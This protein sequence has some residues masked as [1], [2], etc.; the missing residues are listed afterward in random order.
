[1]SKFLTTAVT[2]CETNVFKEK[3]LYKTLS[4]YNEYLLVENKKTIENN[5]NKYI[6][7]N[8]SNKYYMLISNKNDIQTK[9][10][11]L[12]FFPDQYN[13]VNYL[14]KNILSDFYIEIDS[15][16]FDKNYL[17]EGYFYNENKEFMITDVLSID[18]K[19]VTCD[20]SLRYSLINKIIISS[21][22]SNLNA[23]LTISIHSIFYMNEDENES[24]LFNI[25][26]NN[27]IF[28]N[29][30]NCIEYTK[31]SCLEK[32]RCINKDIDKDIISIKK[33]HKSKYIDVYNINNIS[34]NNNEGIL[35]IKTIA[36]SKKLRE[37]FLKEIEIEL[38]C[39]FNNHFNKWYP[40]NF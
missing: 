37:L 2:F 7:P 21:K 1:M 10:K 17:F 3:Y 15:N 26:K 5:K 6:I 4:L 12:Y 30:I 39:K 16:L 31:E 9:Y 13:V 25:F 11:I 28:K 14:N 22:L 27:F 33:V 40:C 18:N 36:T 19:I 34:S 32:T 23:H 29:E 20:Y 35:Y 24:I 8:N 38:E